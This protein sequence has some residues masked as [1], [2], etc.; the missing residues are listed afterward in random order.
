[1]YEL[2]EQNVR[3]SETIRENRT[4]GAKRTLISSKALQKKERGTFDF[5]TDGKVFVAKCTTI[6]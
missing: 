3:A 1:M 4:R 6:Q 2:G 5:C